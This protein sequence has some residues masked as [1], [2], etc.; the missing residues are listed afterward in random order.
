M[1][2]VTETKITT[3]KDAVQRLQWRFKESIRLNKPFTVNQSD[4]QAL[5][6]LLRTIN[7][8]SETTLQDNRLFAKLYIVMLQDF[9]IHYKSVMMAQKQLNKIL[10]NNSVEALCMDM[11]NKLNQM[12]GQKEL[13]TEGCDPRRWVESSETWD[14][15]SVTANV[16]ATV[17]QAINNYKNL[18]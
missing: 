8:N 2:T 14:L 12:E 7:Q 17:T 3:L 11:V 5:N 1:S 18:P 6:I 15:D 4:A 13:E 10:M 9:A 16:N